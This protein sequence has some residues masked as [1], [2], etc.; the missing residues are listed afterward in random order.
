MKGLPP[1]AITRTCQDS[2]KVYFESEGEVARRLY[3]DDGGPSYRSGHPGRRGW[4]DPQ[5]D[6]GMYNPEWHIVINLPVSLM[7]LYRLTFY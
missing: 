3:M 1:P 7:W 4:V 2:R 5:K 6:F